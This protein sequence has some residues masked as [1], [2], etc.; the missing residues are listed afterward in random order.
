[1][2]WP[3]ELTVAV[4]L[5]PAQFSQGSVFDV[6]RNA[7][8]S[9]G[10]SAGRLQLEITEGLLLHDTDSILDELRRI[11]GLGVAIVMDDFGTG[12]SSL[13][14]L[15]RFPFDKL[16]I[17]ASFMLAMK[18]H[19]ETI[20]TVVKTIVG[21]GHLLQMKVTIEGVEN[22]WQVGFVREVACDEVQ[23]F[24]YGRPSPAAQVTIEIMRNFARAAPR[25]RDGTRGRI[26]AAG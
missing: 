14:Y 3:D 23:G 22:E 18:Q 11:K 16:K 7:L 17:D 15:W 25:V 5:S 24:Y 9:S 13:S 1:M 20:E 8:S 2:T 19:D 4:N 6:V 10:L 12:Y 26:A 21:L